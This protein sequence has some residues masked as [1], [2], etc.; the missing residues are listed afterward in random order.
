MHEP[1]IHTEREELVGYLRQ[2]FDGLRNA[3]YGLTEQQ[4]RQRPCVSELSIGG[5]L[6]HAAYFARGW[7]RR[8]A[9][10]QPPTPAEVAAFFASFALTE[11]E[12]LDDVLV[13]FDAAREEFLGLIAA[14]DPDTRMMVPPA[15]WFGRLEPAETT[16]R[17]AILQALEE[18][19]RHAGH[20]DIIREQLDG[21]TAM[22]LS[23]AVEGRPANPF[24][25]PWEPT[26]Q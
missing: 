22:P 9:A 6:K 20:A 4:A 21:A 2:E 25:T 11:D 24:V 1:G 7:R 12:S 8:L 3:A 17:F 19:A 16:I 15:P 26:R 14:A 13:K 23:A 10:G 5:L 18:L